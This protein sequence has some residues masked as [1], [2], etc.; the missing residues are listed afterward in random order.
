MGVAA[1]PDRRERSPRDPDPR[2]HD[3]SLR[4]FIDILGAGCLLVLA[5][6]LLAGAALGVLVTSGRPVFY[7]HPRVGRFGVPFRCWKLRTMA[8]DADRRLSEDPGL[9]R[10]YVENGYKIPADSDP[11]ITPLGH[12]LRRTYLDELPQLVNVLNGTMS[13]VGPRPVVEEELKE[14]EP[15]TDEL[16]SVRP[17]IFGAWTSL[18]RR[19]PG[20]PERSRIEIEYVRTRGPARDLPILARSLPVVLSG[21]KHRE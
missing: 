1:A 21:A 15:D 11:R 3:G 2:G 16:L 17:G 6:P 10:S 20:Y 8:A 5:L 18:G 7:G 14:F 12:W 19:R 4:R 13:L 9:R